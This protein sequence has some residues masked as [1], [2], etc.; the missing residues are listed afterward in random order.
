VRA[1]S[2][3]AGRWRSAAAGAAAVAI[4]AVAAS[5]AA[6]QDRVR[7]PADPWEPM[8]RGL[9]SV[10]KVLDKVLVRPLMLVYTH[11]TPSPL[12]A[13]LR[14]AAGNLGEPITFVNDVLQVK[15]KR[16]GRTLTR[17]ATNSTIG[18]LGV[19]DV[20]SAAGLPARHYSDFG[21][22]LGRY[23][24]GPGPFLFLPIL[25]PSSVRD[26]GGRVVDNFADPV[27]WVH[28]E[29]D[30]YVRIAR[31]T[32]NGLE[33]RAFFDMEI[34]QL[35]QTATDP[36]V[37]LRSAYLQN[38]RSLVSDGQVDVEALP[39][40]EPEAPAPAPSPAPAQ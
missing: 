5:P 29:G 35:D 32:V 38:R 6:A 4:A 16:A 36:Y 1:S 20:A 10:H 14:N 25:G 13:G 7:D 15:P 2:R 3:L 28:Y 19:F 18:V 40:F 17:F 11:V 37:T 24:I 22:T 39:S 27:N 26:V 9:Y 31:P 30:T 34:Q 33:L 8:N 21:Q 23:G 12:R